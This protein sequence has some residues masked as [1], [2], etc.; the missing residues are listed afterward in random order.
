MTLVRDVI[1]VSPWQVLD[2][3]RRSER[4]GHAGVQAILDAC[5]ADVAGVR[6][7]M[8]IAVEL[9]DGT[10]HQWVVSAI[11]VVH[12]VPAFFIAGATEH[13]VPPGSRLTWSA[14]QRASLGD[15]A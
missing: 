5:A 8:P 11:E 1:P 2:G 14:S 6:G 10:R 12:D 7:G 13:D 4:V 15:G 9:P 3:R